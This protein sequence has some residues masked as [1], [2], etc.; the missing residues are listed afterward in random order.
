MRAKSNSRSRA[1]RAKRFAAGLAFFVLGGTT[2]AA[3]S[4]ARHPEERKGCAA[5]SRGNYAV[6]SVRRPHCG[7]AGC[8]SAGVCR[9]PDRPAG[10]VDPQRPRPD[11]VRRLSLGRQGRARRPD[12]DPSRPQVADA[13]R[14]SCGS[15]DRHR[16]D[17]VRRR[18]RADPGRQVSDPARRSRII[19]RRPTTR[20]CPT[21]CG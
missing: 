16:R 6:S 8:T 20:R 9:R 13:V 11:A 14:L 7:V 19:A 18:R 4:V 17:P 15:R 1:R 2:A 10:Q 21:R 5:P 3:W 12:L